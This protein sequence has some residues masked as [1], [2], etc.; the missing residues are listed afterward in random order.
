M[1]LDIDHGLVGLEAGVQIDQ[2]RNIGDSLLHDLAQAGQFVQIRA[3]EREL[4]LLL[5][6]HGLAQATWVR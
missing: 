6:A 1:D 5:P 4:D 3:H 2:A